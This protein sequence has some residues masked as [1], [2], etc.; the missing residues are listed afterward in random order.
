MVGATSTT[1]SREITVPT[2]GTWKA[3]ARAI[4]TTGQSDLDTA[5]AR[6]DRQRGRRGAEGV[7]QRARRDGAADRR[8]DAGTYAPGSPLTFRGSATDDEGLNNVEIRLRNT[9]TRE[10]LAADGTWSTNAI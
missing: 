8:A 3:Q 10:N 7:H 4:D 2:E 1:W 5:D 9:T 6:V